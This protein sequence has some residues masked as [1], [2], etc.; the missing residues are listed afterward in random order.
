M[1]ESSGLLDRE[2]KAEGLK[3]TDMTTDRAFG[4]T[5][6]E[7]VGPKLL[8]GHAVA[9]DVERNLKDLMPNGHDRVLC[10]NSAEAGSSDNRRI[11]AVGGG[12]CVGN[13]AQI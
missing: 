8:V 10:E 5:L 2:V 11:D 1:S 4:V 13:S 7:V 3:L 9:H 6:V 12:L